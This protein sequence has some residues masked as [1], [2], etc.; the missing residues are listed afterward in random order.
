AAVVA[1]S[2]LARADGFVVPGLAV[3]Y[4]LVAGRR[5]E[6]LT[7]GAALGLTVAALVGWRLS[8]YGYPLPNTYYAKVSGPLGERLVQG[9]LQLL[10]IALHGGL[11]PHMAGLVLAAA[12]CAWRPARLPGP[13]VRFE[14]VL[15]F[16]WLA[17]W[18]YVGG[19]V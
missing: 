15:G 14:I 6:S 4:L 1:L 13:R 16:V 3:L 17:Y 5:R 19:D 10:S 18:L 7:A 11:L 9:T 8:Y 2:V 12:A